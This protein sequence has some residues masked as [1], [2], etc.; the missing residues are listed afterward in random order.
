M[1][2]IK[3]DP[4]SSSSIEPQLHEVFYKVFL[5]RPSLR[6][7]AVPDKV[8]KS[9]FAYS[10]EMYDDIEYVGNISWQE[11][12]PYRGDT[13]LTYIIK[14]PNVRKSK[15]PHDSLLTTK[16]D[17]AIKILL[18]DL[19][20]KKRPMDE[21]I[22][23]ILEQAKSEV[24][25]LT[26]RAMYRLDIR[27]LDNIDIMDFLIKYEAGLSPNLSDY[28]FHRNLTNENKE[29]V[30]DYNILKDICSHMEKGN[31]HYIEYEIDDSLTAYSCKDKAIVYQGSNTYELPVWAQSKLAML[32][33]IDVNQAIRG[34]GVKAEVNDRVGYI[35]VDGEIPDLIQ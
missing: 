5:K 25:H 29:V 10:F 14:S 11:H 12:T 13:K 30:A 7:V 19:V 26:S 8:N 31:F 22:E 21:K 33:M 9:G 35:V 16:T 28:P 34:V 24:S 4:Q 17:K 6:Y 3:F 2:T 15:Y 23:R 1:Y 27:R 20:I 32:K 18:D